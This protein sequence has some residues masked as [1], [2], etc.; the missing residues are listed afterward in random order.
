MNIPVGSWQLWAVLSAGSLHLR[1]SL[2]KSDREYQ[3]GLRD[4]NSNSSDTARARGHRHCYG[5]MAIAR[6]RGLSH[7]PVSRSFRPCDRSIMAVLF[8]G[9]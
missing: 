1:P 8:P 6:L 4:L 9:T 7:V 5:A 3:F 2:Q